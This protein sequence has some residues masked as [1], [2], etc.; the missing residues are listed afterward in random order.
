M[1]IFHVRVSGDKSKECVCDPN[2]I[3]DGIVVRLFIDRG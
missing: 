1:S 3:L 2:V